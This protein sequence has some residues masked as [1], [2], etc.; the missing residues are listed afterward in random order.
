M[1]RRILYSDTPNVVA[2]CHV[3]ICCRRLD[4]VEVL[5]RRLLIHFVRWMHFDVVLLGYFESSIQIPP[6]IIILTTR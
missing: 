1:A 5:L 6:E 4:V 3:G 2:T